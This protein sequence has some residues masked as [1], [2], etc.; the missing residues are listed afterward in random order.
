[1]KFSP[2]SK[3]EFFANLAIIIV[4]VLLGI[5][6][7][8]QYLITSPTKDNKNPDSA[9][10]LKYQNGKQIVLESVNWSKNGQT[11]LLILSS[12]CRYCTDSAPFYRRLKQEYNINQIA[13]FPEDIN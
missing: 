13:V 11:V 8:K 4:S 1:M 2:F 6:L 7:I 5:V 10:Y 3:I 12:S 9:S